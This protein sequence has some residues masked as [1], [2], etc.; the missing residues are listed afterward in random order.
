MLGS[1]VGPCHRDRKERAT[2]SESEVFW[3]KTLD[4]GSNRGSSHQAQAG[5]SLLGSVLSAW[6]SL[7]GVD[8]EKSTNKG[9]QTLLL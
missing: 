7:S 4:L 8:R 1:C 9:R 2:R 5:K 3:E 6:D